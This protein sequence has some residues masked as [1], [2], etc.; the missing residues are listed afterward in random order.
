M[1]KFKIVVNNLERPCDK[2]TIVTPHLANY[3]MAL[4]WLELNAP[5]R[6]YGIVSSKKED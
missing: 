4:V 6:Y 2:T 3:N 1:V 5:Y